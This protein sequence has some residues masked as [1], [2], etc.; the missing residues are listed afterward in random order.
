MSKPNK[1]LCQ[2]CKK[3]KSFH[4]GGFKST[5]KQIEVASAAFSTGIT[6]GTTIDSREKSFPRFRNLKEKT[7]KGKSNSGWIIKTGRFRESEGKGVSNNLNFSQ[8]VQPEQAY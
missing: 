5:N 6:L 2:A 1:D 7:C 4:G 3:E 8:Y